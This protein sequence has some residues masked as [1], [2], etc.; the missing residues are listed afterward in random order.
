[1]SGRKFKVLETNKKN[2]TKNEI[3]DRKAIQDKASDGLKA[4]QKSAPNHL[5]PIARYEY[6]RV[7]E[8]LQ[9][10][11]VKNLDR[12]VLELYCT[13]YAIYR[14]AEKDVKENGIFTYGFETKT[15]IDKETGDEKSI[16]KKVIDTTRK[17]PSL[18]VM[19]DA[20][21]N[22]MRCASNL[23]L[24]VDSR[25][26]IYTPPKEEKKQTLADMFG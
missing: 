1:M 10:L 6:E 9:N 16:S 8:D 21:S 3:A 4:L 14:E 24:T 12:A 19:N 15:T 11:P 26:R 18:S 20:S 22:I 23:G 2:F 7:W 5:N 13:W 25:L 17:N